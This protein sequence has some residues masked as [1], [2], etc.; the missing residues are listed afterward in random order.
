MIEQTMKDYLSTALSVPVL[1]EMPAKLP[2]RFVTLEKTGSGEE[3]YIFRSTMTIQSYGPS[4]LEAAQLHER[5][6]VAMN[7]LLELDEIGAVRLNSD[8]N[9]TD[10]TIK[11]YRY[12]AVYDIT[13]Y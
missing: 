11:R 2:N 3:N 12:Q 13:H 5:V 9:F 6:K 7:Q 1:W 10:T 4:L 8:Y